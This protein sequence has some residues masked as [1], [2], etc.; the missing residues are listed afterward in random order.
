MD[1]NH[2]TREEI[3]L[4]RRTFAIADEITRRRW[5]RIGWMAYFAML[6]VSLIVTLNILYG[7]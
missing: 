1:H 6:S 3:F 4:A 2:W 5:E 7:V